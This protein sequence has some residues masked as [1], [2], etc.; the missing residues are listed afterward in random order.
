MID[1][2]TILYQY[3]YRETFRVPKYRFRPSLANLKLMEGFVSK[4]DH[5]V[6]EGWLYDYVCYQFQRVKDFESKFYGARVMPSWIFGPKALKR[7]K[8]ASFEEKSYAEK[9]KI[10]LGLKNPLLKIGKVDL[11][12]LFENE[13]GR[14]YGTYRG[15]VHCLM[16]E[17]FDE[18]SGF[19]DKCIHRPVCDEKIDDRK[20]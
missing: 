11:R 8:E 1:K 17:L 15:L 5:S 12:S 7:Y 4:L 10:A 6:G 2:L 16:L 19:C 9:F 13:R 14:F 18:K 20:V 3:L